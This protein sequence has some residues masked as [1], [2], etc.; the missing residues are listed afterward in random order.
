MVVT[1][2]QLGDFV[3]VTDPTEPSA[4]AKSDTSHI[5]SESSEIERIIVFY[6]DKTYKGLVYMPDPKTKEDHV[7][8]PNMLELILPK[9]K[10]LEYGLMVD[11]AL[12][13]DQLAI[14]AN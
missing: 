4:P 12:K 2:H 8:I 14:I 13:K 5:A 6:K 9:I 7:Q 11:I 3:V 10:G 1:L